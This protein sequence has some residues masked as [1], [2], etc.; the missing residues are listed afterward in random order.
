MSLIVIKNFV[1]KKRRG[2][3]LLFTIVTLCCCMSC[4]VSVPNY[5]AAPVFDYLINSL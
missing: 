2:I 4:S 1:M 3:R 5:L